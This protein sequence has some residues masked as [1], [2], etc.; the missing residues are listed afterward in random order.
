ML[1]FTELSN[2]AIRV[3]QRVK[4]ARTEVE[5]RTNFTD[6]AIILTSPIQRQFK[7]SR[8]VGTFPGDSGKCPCAQSSNRDCV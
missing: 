4:E 6:T 2:D 8:T 3:R 7:H 1:P 5:V